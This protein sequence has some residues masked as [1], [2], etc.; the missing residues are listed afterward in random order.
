MW[1]A[2]V[3]LLAGAWLTSACTT[4][5]T[6]NGVPV[7]DAGQSTPQPEGSPRRRAEIRLQLAA[8][9]YQAGKL[10]IALD[11]V[12]RA[13]SIDPTYAAAHSMLG[14]IHLELGDRREADANYAQALRLEPDN[15]EI[16]NNHGWYLCQTGRERESIEFFKRAA[17]N[18][19]YR[20]PALA[21]QN[22]GLC[23]L[24]INDVTAAEGFLH[25]SFELD[26]S[27]PV[28]KY[29]LARLYL[30]KRELDR[31]GFYYGLLDRGPDVP[32]P[33]L[34]LGVRIAHAKGD[35]RQERELAEELRRRFPDSPEAR[36]L[37]RGAFNE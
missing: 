18:R 37:S 12:R 28:A 33:V 29:E 1:R 27:N 8:S 30:A 31:A 35:G 19:L 24:R 26:A 13:L 20:T 36:A 25:R 14:L 22:A 21:M 2:L 32:A 10:S 34:W 11:E 9:Y 16:Q 17:A 23:M 5:T 15:P 4:T 7:A 6:V 3:V